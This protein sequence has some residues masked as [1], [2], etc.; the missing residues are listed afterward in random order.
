MPIDPSWYPWTLERQAAH[1]AVPDDVLHTAVTLLETMQRRLD[2]LE[3]DVRALRRAR[4]TTSGGTY[5]GQW[6][7]DEPDAFRDGVT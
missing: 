5:E 2:T 4:G 6:D 3:A 1:A 7:E